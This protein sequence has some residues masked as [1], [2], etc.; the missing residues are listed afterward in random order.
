MRHSQLICRQV[1]LIPE[2]LE[3]GVLYISH[4]YSTA[5]HRC[6]CG[7]GEEVVTPLGPT[8]WSVRVVAG[9]ATVHPSIGNWSYACR[10]HYWI[11]RGKVVWAG[12]MSGSEIEA[13][14]ARDR[15]AKRA[16]FDEI[17]RE[18][19]SPNQSPLLTLK[20]S[21]FDLLERAWKLTMRWLRS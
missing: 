20:G 14:R 2:Q 11:R 4:R 13:G 6:C 18:A 16:Y 19:R 10:S 1:E 5:V 12:S 15:A 8:D 21:K 3:D 17:N 9:L 7:C